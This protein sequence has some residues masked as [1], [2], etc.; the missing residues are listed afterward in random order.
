M[1]EKRVPNARSLALD[2]LMGWERHRRPLDPILHQALTRSHLPQGERALAYALVTGTVRW[3]RPLREE[4]AAL[5]SRP[6]ELLPPVVRSII[7]LGLFQVRRLDRIPPYAVVSTAVDL[8]GERGHRGTASL[9]NAVLRR[10]LREGPP[11]PPAPADPAARLGS[12]G[13]FPDWMVRRWI[14]RWGEERAA[15]WMEFSNGVAPLTVRV[16][17]P[18]GSRDAALA[19][20]TDSGVAARAAGRSPAGI[21]LGEG[22]GP[23]ALERV[24]PGVWLAQDEA[25]QLVAPLLNVRPG[26]RVLDAAAAPGGKTAHLFD[27]MRGEGELVAADR[28]PQRIALLRGTLDR[29]GIRG[30]TTSVT[31]LLTPPAEW[32]GRFDAVLLDAPC[33]GLGTIRRHPDIKWTR[34]PGD[35][36]RLAREQRLLLASCLT[37]L[38]PGGRLLYSTCTTEPE[39]DAMVVEEAVRAGQ[40][41]VDPIGADE[42]HGGD[43]L[44]GP[45][46]FTAPG[47][48]MDGF[49]AARLVRPGD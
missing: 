26:E 46:F 35:L 9:V 7:L 29:L 2:V 41:A 31:D 16:Q 33:S 6:L 12:A 1:K 18:P 24:I 45:W 28:S 5:C 40:A 25:A 15:G 48:G 44:D 20:L 27:L 32:L 43:L 23:D 36:S 17:G 3:L 21:I 49:F 19:R 37:L 13:S 10:A 22:V 47:G 14:D 4:A 42:A 38:A 8:A 39:E 11:V 34:A 30:V